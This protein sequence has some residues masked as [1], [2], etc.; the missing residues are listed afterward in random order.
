MNMPMMKCGHVAQGVESETKKPICIICMGIH[1]GATEVDDTP[2][3]LTGRKARCSYF[4]RCG[5]EVDSN[6]KLAFF[7]YEPN[8][9]F[10]EFYC[11]CYGWE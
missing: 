5:T 4:R 3:D 2:P 11:D 1:T 10:D 7:G 9:E 6:Y 8:R